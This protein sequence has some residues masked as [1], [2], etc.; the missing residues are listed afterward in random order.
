MSGYLLYRM[1]DHRGQGDGKLS[2]IGYGFPELLERSRTFL[3]HSEDSQ[4]LYEKRQQEFQRNV[5]ETEVCTERLLCCFLYSF[6]MPGFY[7]GDF[8]TK[9]KM[10]VFDG[11]AAEELEMA[12]YFIDSEEEELCAA[13]DFKDFEKDERIL[14]FSRTAYLFARQIENSAENKDLLEQLLKQPEF[15]IRRIIETKSWF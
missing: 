14:R 6:V 12:E 5:P 2:P 11:V 15:G 1:G 13:E 3:Y 7:D 9:A 8:Y 10:A 4:S